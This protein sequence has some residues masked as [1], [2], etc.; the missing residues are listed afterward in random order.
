M[1]RT[2][3]IAAIYSSL[4]FLAFGLSVL[5]LLTDTN[6]RT[7][8]GSMSSGYY[9][10]WYVILV[11]AIVDVIGG[12]LLVVVGSRIAIKA[13]VVGAGLIALIF[14]GDILTYGQVGFSSASAFASYLLGWT[15]SGGNIR[16]LYDVLLAVYI[17]AFISGTVALAKTRP[18]GLSH[19]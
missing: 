11:I 9:A 13:G 4:F 12:V 10:H 3:A 17:V 7:D 2:N 5:M 19:P 6:L 15:Y 16:Y 18:S 14:V 8:F 1:E